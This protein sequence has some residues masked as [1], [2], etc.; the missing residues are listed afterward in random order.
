MQDIC[1][2]TGVFW[3][4]SIHQFTHPHMS[5]YEIGLKFEKPS[6]NFKY[7]PDPQLSANINNL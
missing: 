1:Y 7:L 2:T 6:L 4:L 3:A 5:P